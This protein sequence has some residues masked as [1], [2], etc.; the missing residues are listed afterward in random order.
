M[1]RVVRAH[2]EFAVLFELEAETVLRIA[3]AAIEYDVVS[4]YGHADHL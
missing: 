1:T 4:D 3:R 2:V